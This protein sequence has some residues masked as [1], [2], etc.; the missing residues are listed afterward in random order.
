MRCLKRFGAYLAVLFLI[1]VPF[2]RVG[3]EAQVIYRCGSQ[4]GR[5]LVAL[6]FDDGP[7]PVYTPKILDILKSEGIQATFFAVGENV[8]AYPELA[9]R[10]VREGHELGNHTFH[11]NHMAK[12]SF[13]DLTK[14]INLCNDAIE[15]VTG[16][17]PRYFRPPEGKFSRDMLQCIKELGYKTVFWSFAYADW[18]NNKQ[19]D[20]Q[21]AMQC[22]MDNIHNGAVLLLHPT[23]ATN[24]EILPRII[25][26]LKAQ[27]YRFGTLEELCGDF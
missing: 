14:D 20:P 7:H 18:D 1:C 27:G 4:T 2:M 19:P 13:E 17:R 26:E 22:V 15:R 9:G 24:A 5:R 21:K 12:M 3:A 25:A 8:E 16:E 23:S 10:I 6:T 11:H